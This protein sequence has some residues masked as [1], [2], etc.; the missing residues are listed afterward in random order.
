MEPVVHGDT[1]QKQVT[2]ADV[3]LLMSRDATWEKPY[4]QRRWS[5]G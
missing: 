5:W 3:R 4:R 1:E 2:E